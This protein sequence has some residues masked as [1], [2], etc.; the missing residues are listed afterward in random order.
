MGTKHAEFLAREQ[1]AT[2]VG[3]ADPFTTT[4]AETTEV[5]SYTDYH[6][7]LAAPDVDAVIIANPNVEHVPTALAAIEAGI[8]ALLEKPVAVSADE[9]SMLSLAV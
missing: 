9:A 4:L 6:D 5:P 8:P 7:L 1:N 2:L 3:I